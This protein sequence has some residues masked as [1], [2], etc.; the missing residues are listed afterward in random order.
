LPSGDEDLEPGLEAQ[1]RAQLA[2]QAAL[3]AQLDAAALREAT[4]KS[5]VLVKRLRENINKDA[6]LSTHIVRSWLNEGS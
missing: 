3:Q 6:T 2:E 5:A 4:K 1:R